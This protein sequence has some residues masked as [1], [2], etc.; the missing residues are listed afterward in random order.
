M[1]GNRF[2]L[3]FGSLKVGVVTQTDSDFPNLWG[4]L[5]YDPA[6]ANPQSAEVARLAKFVA[7]NRESTRLVDMEYETD[8]SREQE[9]VNAELE[10]H[11]ADYLESEDWHL[12]CCR[13]AADL[14]RLGRHDREGACGVN[15]Y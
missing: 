2:D 3:C 10:A 15:W 4:S 11:Y 12:S 14:P 8:T 5:T 13:W 7:L 9:V 1:G 6:L